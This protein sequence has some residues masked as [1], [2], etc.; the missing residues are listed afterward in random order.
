MRNLVPFLLFA[1]AVVIVGLLGLLLINRGKNETPKTTVTNFEDCAASGN[2]VQ[3]SYPRRCSANGK[4]F[5]EDIGNSLDKQDLIR[6]ETPAPNQVVA[7]PLT[8]KGEA[9]GKWFFEASF[10]VKIVDGSSKVLGTAIASTTSD[11]MTDSFVP[12]TATLTFEKPT[13][14]KGKLI[15][16]KDNPSGLSENADAL[17]IPVKFK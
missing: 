16:E 3:E 10:P 6:L 9:R 15:L 11:W 13:T 2:P 12:F 8:I 7:S 14:D 17:E 5:T 1:G 4:T